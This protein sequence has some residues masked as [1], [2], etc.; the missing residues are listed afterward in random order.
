[1][2]LQITNLEPAMEQ[3]QILINVHF[4]TSLTMQQFQN[5]MMETKEWG[6]DVYV[7][8]GQPEPPKQLGNIQQQPQGQP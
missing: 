8:S 6:V 1:M 7:Q 4:A 2:K 3:G 5:L